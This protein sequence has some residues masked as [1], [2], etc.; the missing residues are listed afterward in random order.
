MTVQNTS[1]FLAAPTR[2][3]LDG[4]LS[5]LKHLLRQDEGCDPRVLRRLDRILRLRLT[6]LLR[7]SADAEAVI[8]EIEGIR[9]LM[10][11]KRREEPSNLRWSLRW[12][13]FGDLLD[14]YAGWLQSYSDKVT[15]LAHAGEIMRLVEKNPG[16]SQ[17]EIGRQLDLKPPNLSRILGA[18]EAQGHI[19]RRPDGRE[20]KV[21]AASAGMPVITAA[22]TT[23]I[24]G[25]SEAQRDSKMVSKD[26][27]KA[28]VIQF[29]KTPETAQGEKESTHDSST[30]NVAA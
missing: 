16:L 23:G 18:L 19:L 20:K 21:Y 15:N 28:S 8:H 25:T 12:E 17:V 5:S 4:E 29:K 22:S 30:E 7:T 14:T 3:L 11:H 2:I 26:A 10:P 24:G 13:A 9:R 1:D 6:R 27:D